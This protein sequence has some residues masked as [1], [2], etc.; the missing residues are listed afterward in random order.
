M[1]NLFRGAGLYAALICGLC[2][3][4]VLTGQ[5]P[6]ITS[7]PIDTTFNCDENIKSELASWVDAGGYMQA[8]NV[9]G[10]FGSTRSGTA[11]ETE[12]DNLLDTECPSNAYNITVG[13]WAINTF[14]TSDT[15]SATF[16]F[17][18]NNSPQVVLGGRDISLGC[19]FSNIDSLNSWIRNAGGAVA[20][21]PCKGEVPWT[22]FTWN[23]EGRSGSGN[24]ND[25]S[26]DIIDNQ[27]CDQSI[28]FIFLASNG[29]D[30]SVTDTAIFELFTDSTKL[31]IDTIATD[32]LLDCTESDIGTKI[33]TWYINNAGLQVTSFV[34][35]VTYS[36]NK[37]LDSVLTELSRN[38]T[39]SCAD[40]TIS[41]AFSASDT[42]GGVEGPFAVSIEV[43]DTQ[44]PSFTSNS[45]DLTLL[46]RDQN[47]D[48]SLQGWVQN[49][50][51]AIATDNCTDSV[52]WTGFNWSSG[53]RSGSGNFISGPFN[54]IIDVNNCDQEIVFTFVAE[55][56]CGNSSQVASTFTIL[57]TAL[58][59]VKQASDININCELV[60]PIPL[61]TDWHNQRAGFEGVSAGMPLTSQTTKSLSET[62]AEYNTSILDK[63]NEGSVTVGFFG[64]D[65]LGN[66][67]DTILASFTTMDESGPVI[68]I[69]PSNISFDC[70]TVDSTLVQSWIQSQGGASATDL[71]SDS[72]FWTEFKW[73]DSNG[74]TGGGNF[75]TG[76]FNILDG[77]DC[78]SS[79]DVTFVVSDPCGNT[80]SSVA[81][82]SIRDTTP[83]MDVVPPVITQIPRD[84]ETD[85]SIDILDSLKS[86]FDSYGGLMA[87]D[88]NGVINLQATKTF[89]LTQQDFNAS[90]IKSGCKNGNVSVGFFA[91]DTLNNSSDTVFASFSATDT[92]PPSIVD[93]PVDFSM[94]CNVGKQDSLRNWI[95]RFGGARAVDDC[96]DD[97]VIWAQFT[98][99]DIK[100]NTGSGT[101]MNGPFNIIGDTLCDW[102]VDV[103][104]QVQDAC[105]N[106]QSTQAQFAIFDNQAPVFQLVLH[107]T[108]FNCDN[109]PSATAIIADDACE[110]QIMATATDSTTQSQDPNSCGFFN[111]KLFRTYAVK[112][113][114]GNSSSFTQIITVSDTLEPR[115]EAPPN[116]TISCLDDTNPSVTGEPINVV[117][118]CASEVVITFTDSPI[119]SGCD[120]QIIRTWEIKDLC[121]S[122]LILPQTISIRDTIPPT[123]NVA[124]SDEVMACSD[125]LDFDQAFASWLGLMG[126]A[127][128]GEECGSLTQSF[129]A[130]PGSYD[131]LDPTTFP[132]ESP[133]AL[134]LVS[135]P[136]SEPGLSRFEIVDFVF[137]D[138]CG[139]ASVSSASFKITDNIAPIIS[140]GGTDTVLIIND[141][142]VCALDIVIPALSVE[143][144]CD[145]IDNSFSVTDRYD[146]TSGEFGNEQVPVDSFTARF[147]PLNASNFTSDDGV[148]LTIMMINIDA[149]DPTEFFNIVAE[150]GTDL[151][152]TPNTLS[153]CGDTTF[154]INLTSN[155][156]RNWAVDG[157]VEID[158]IPNI[159][160][161]L[162]GALAINDVCFGAGTRIIFSLDVEL[163]ISGFIDYK[164]QIDN[165]SPIELESVENHSVA[166]ESGV[167]TITYLVSDCAGNVASSSYTV[168][169][170]ESGLPTITCPANT[171]VVL[172]FGG[173]SIDYLLPLPSDVSDNCTLSDT[174]QYAV[175]GATEKDSVKFQ[176]NEAPISNLNKGVN[177]LT[178]TIYDRSSNSASCSFVITVEDVES[179]IIECKQN[180]L[181]QAHPSGVLPLIV[182]PEDVINSATD[183]CELGDYQY[184]NIDFSCA[185]IGDTVDITVI[186]SDASGNSSQCVSSVTIIPFD[187]QPIAQS[188]VCAGDTLQLS[189]NVPPVAN[190]NPYSFNWT[191]PNGFMSSL[192]NPSISNSTPDLSGAYNVIVVGASGCRS[193]GSVDVAIENF[194]KPDIGVDRDTICEGEL[195]VFAATD[196]QSSV[197]YKWFTGTAPNGLQIGITQIPT[198]Q[199]SPSFGELDYYVVAENEA[200]ETTPSDKLSIT[201][202]PIPPVALKDT[203]IILCERGTF[204][205]GTTYVGG[206][207]TKYMWTGPEG[208]VSDLANPPAFTNAS[209]DL[210]G[211]YTLIIEEN[212]CNSE[213]GTTT[214]VVQSFPQKPSIQTN[215][216]VCEGENLILFLTDTVSNTGTLNW[217]LDG[218][219]YSAV[220][221]NGLIIPN[222]ND[223]L[224]G[225]WQVYIQDGPCTSDTSNGVLITVQELIDVRILNDT[226][227]C[228]SDEV[229]LTT[230]SIMNVSYEWS[231]P[232]NFISTL[233]SPIT[234]I[235]SGTYSVT[236]T[237]AES[238]ASVTSIDIDAIEKPTIVQIS[239]DIMECSDGTTDIVI[240]AMAGPDSNYIFEWE[241]PNNFVSTGDTLRLENVTSIESGAYILTVSSDVCD[242]DPETVNIIITDIPATP[243]LGEDIMACVGDEV[244]LTVQNH[245]EGIDKYEWTTP[246]GVFETDVPSF[247][248]PAIGISNA[249]IY[250]VIAE[251]NGCQSETSDF[252]NVNVFTIPRSPGV[253]S[254]A[255]VCTGDD[256][257]LQAEQIVNAEYLW[258]GPNGFT[259]TGDRVVIRNTD[260]SFEG[261][262]S[263]QIILNDCPSD[264]SV[265]SD[266]EF[267]PRP[268]KPITEQKEIDICQEH[269]VTVSLCIDPA[270]YNPDG[271]YIWTN[272]TTE[273][274]LGRTSERCLVLADDSPILLGENRI[275]VEELNDI[276]TSE[277]S[278]VLSFVLF[279]TLNA[280]PNGGV[281]I[282][283]C[284]LSNVQLDA[285]NPQQGTGRWR[286]LDPGIRFS[287]DTDPKSLVFDLSEGENILIWQLENG[288][289]LGE[290]DTVIVSTEITAQANDDEVETPYNTKFDFDPLLNDDLPA[291][292]TFEIISPPRNGGFFVNDLGQYV[293]NP[294]PGFIGSVEIVYEICSSLCANNCDRATITVNVGDA[295]DCFA[296]SLITPNGDGINDAFVIPCIESGLYPNNQLYIYNQYGDQVLEAFNY[297][298]EWQGKYNGKDLPTGTYYFVFRANDQ[299]APEKGFLII[300]R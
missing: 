24:V 277:A 71:C 32:L 22:T 86:W 242:S 52:L 159:P 187:L 80:S 168:E 205:L 239:D 216:V 77:M 191:G 158:F 284:D 3:S 292:F 135:C 140:G 115:F 188:L 149:D 118:N 264:A 38:R 261:D 4:N 280:I 175:E 33:T 113:I 229:Q 39:M 165:N 172:P 240:S 196:Y 257:I 61:L 69:A 107:D 185:N 49:Y 147:G 101:F 109:V 50:G 297:N 246:M 298:N 251:D 120:R 85:C 293:Y 73:T 68:N 201:I 108:T 181:V 129:A 170:R 173:C 294:E 247:V 199:Y 224:E 209:T 235:Q 139:N 243:D 41:V 266:I 192:E 125:G 274:V 143:D 34:S 150:D 95:R 36:A 166:L 133:G 151:G 26:F 27:R 183:N 47:I 174:F 228:A 219:F 282:V 194:N 11:L 45:S 156:F 178:Y 291:Q 83:L 94:S 126:G 213:A 72:T 248:I 296:P 289:C 255:P 6:V 260:L 16:S 37:S 131:V 182:T 35:P 58:V 70:S 130:V 287:D 244:T 300:E 169:V 21:D 207:S 145:K 18:D 215:N 273:E 29:C 148:N 162:S 195:A 299:L 283:A 152:R 259:A 14:G 19:D 220:E 218:N 127:V 121:G 221:G 160:E 137:V 88:D 62:I 42:L 60:D 98:W 231:G 116:I 241:G 258:Q 99:T 276:C 142:S 67:T 271:D 90:D 200:C 230:N 208:F 249:G 84:V 206:A 176:A 270:Q 281:D 81:L 252:Y 290:L 89:E 23:S 97:D 9:F 153:Q 163:S 136:S 141:P 193:I 272:L 30:A 256:L 1:R 171:S 155:Q 254:N 164:I 12:L 198:F 184:Q 186:V 203:L 210:S 55:D 2:Y 146:I 91:L 179:P 75:E 31:Q 100:G 227:Q 117:D 57:D 138:D 222:A 237:T 180:G 268:D 87:S 78:F 111:Y 253:S 8:D 204:Q 167:H 25:S 250:L 102:S 93:S 119:G 79:A 286:A 211:D 48:S 226:I 232:N 96:S 263:V 132:G 233:E 262:Y 161:G 63:C 5:A 217:L 122:S 245:T 225:L 212:G 92:I 124:A 214:V 144:A 54:N 267:L 7:P 44:N 74:N 13:F 123:I 43:Q 56:L 128:A 202:N 40:Y 105:G 134:D 154:T 28:E 53:S 20:I 46:C 238:C 223:S 82:F 66:S 114:C 10:G 59:I 112:D 236:V 17:I 269:M 157:F 275:I 103:T 288:V 15:V 76:P 197:V 177:T 64:T 190:G 265:L 234:N 285:S 295:T 106:L 110:G 278:D 104:F 189:A 51:G 65:N 279:E